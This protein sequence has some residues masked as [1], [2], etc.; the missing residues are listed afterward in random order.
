[1]TAP[2]GATTSRVVP[3]P[4]GRGDGHQ[5]SF[6]VYESTLPLFK[7]FAEDYIVEVDGDH[8]RFTWVVAIEPKNA[9]S[10]PVKVLAPVL[11]AGFG[12]IPSG[13]RSYFAKKA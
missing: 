11:K 6:Y 13:G 9:M 1:M 3:T 5:H 10:L 12:R 7:R 4:N 2:P 8:T